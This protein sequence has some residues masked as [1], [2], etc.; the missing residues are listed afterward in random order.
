M[1]KRV[2]IQDIKDRN[3]NTLVEMNRI[4]GGYECE[5]GYCGT[6]NQSGG[7]PGS[8]GGGGGGNMGMGGMGG[9]GGGSMLISRT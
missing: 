3:T 1:G 6:P 7:G 2:K 5:G 9:G 4:K 8:G